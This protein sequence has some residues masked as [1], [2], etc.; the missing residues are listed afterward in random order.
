MTMSAITEF[1]FPAPA[2]RTVGSIVGWWESRRLKYNLVVGGAGVTSLVA[3]RLITLLP[4]HTH[5]L[6]AFFLAAVWRPVLLFA[7]MANVCYTLGP[8]VEVIAEKLWG[9]QVLPVGPS[10]FRMGLTFSV[11]LA[12]LPTLLVIF[13]WIIRIVGAVL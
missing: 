6:P 8:A 12:L 4:P 1:L 13:G 7:V 11:G 5:P 2:R 9:R 10:L 3:V